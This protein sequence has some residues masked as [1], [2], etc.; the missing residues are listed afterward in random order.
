[1]VT[2]ETRD[3]KGT[4][5]SEVRLSG[6]PWNGGL[7]ELGKRAAVVW[8]VGAL[9]ALLIVGIGYAAQVVLLAFA[10]LLV[11]VLLCSLT[12]WVRDYSPL[13]DN[14]SLALVVVVLAGSVVG[15]T[16]VLT[17]LLAKQADQ[18]RHQI[19]QA[20]QE[21]Q[22]RVEQSPHGR[23]VLD[24]A[25]RSEE[26]LPRRSDVFARISGVVSGTM[27]AAGAAFVVF[28]IGLFLA[29]QPR[30]Y[31]DGIVRL[32]PVRKR[33]RARDVLAQVGTALWWW[34][35]GKLMSMAIIGMLTW[36]GLW[37]IGIEMAAALAVLAA[38]LTFIP[39][40]GPIIAAVPAVLAGL[41]QSPT[42]A[43]W[44]FVLY[45]AVQTV[46]SY[47]I[48]PL[49]QQRVVSLPPALTITAQLLMG[50]FA[51]GLGLALATPL[52][53]A[54]L[55]LVR[56]LYIEDVLSERTASNSGP[57]RNHTPV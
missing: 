42:T 57:P 40:F 52:T 24:Q 45:V 26:L 5:L 27:E 47:L 56:T 44:V 25:P 31:L 53:A 46:E 17:P 32:L 21:L 14:S 41:L 18:I 13:G 48:T 33:G 7:V 28:F 4:D 9:V 38:L 43:M 39:N 1:M 23:W 6:T 3:V 36:L 11:A 15:G 55:V 50:L 51:G 37:A 34:L 19:P 29:S 10:G 16:W 12:N 20:F 30:V 2:D 49:I 22:K 35:L 54:A 8:T